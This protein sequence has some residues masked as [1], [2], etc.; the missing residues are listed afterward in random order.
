M[1]WT[2]FV[3]PFEVAFLPVAREATNTV[4]I[5]G[6]VIDGVF[7]VDLVLQFF[8]AYKHK[9][10]SSQF[11]PVWVYNSRKIARRY[12]MSWFLFDVVCL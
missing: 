11:K 10:H 8:I 2:A 5:C 3:L 6:R 4:F 7:L 12:L 1:L 9:E